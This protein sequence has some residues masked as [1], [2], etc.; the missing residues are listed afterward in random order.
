MAP[1][2]KKIASRL[3]S[4]SKRIASS[5]KQTN[6]SHDVKLTA[7]FSTLQFGGACLQKILQ[8]YSPDFQTVLDIGSGQGLHAA[9]FREFGKRVTEVD[10]GTSEYFLKSRENRKVLY[11]HYLEL[12]LVEQFDLIWACHVLEH[13]TNVNQ[14][15]KK[16]HFDLKDNGILAITVPPFKHEVV[17]GHLTVWNAGLLMYNLVLA[18]F[19]CREAKILEYGYNIS[20]ILKKR[21][22]LLPELA[23]DKGDI[24][25]LLEYFPPGSKEPF[26]GN[27]R[28]LNWYV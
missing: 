11:G 14:F 3:L 9:I 12:D 25:K 2:L 6:L 8:E 17:G 13:Q 5:D 1:V 28:E 21:P 4:L 10:F 26:D 20:L 23:Y 16:V 22:A 15:L 27:I 7:P 18:G 24:E 19:N